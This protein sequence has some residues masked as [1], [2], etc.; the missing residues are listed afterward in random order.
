MKSKSYI[1]IETCKKCLFCG[2]V[3]P[4]LLITKDEEGNVIFCQEYDE[5]CIHCGHCMAVCPTDSISIEGLKYGEQVIP[6]S[7]EDLHSD[8][9][10]SLASKRRA[11]RKYKSKEVEIEKV[12]KIIELIEK[13]PVSFTPNNI[14]IT[15]INGREKLEKLFPKMT[16]FYFDLAH[17][18]NSK[19]VNFFIKQS[20]NSQTYTTLKD[21]IKPLFEY[22]E[23]NFGDEVD[24]IFRGAPTVFIFHANKDAGSHTED[25]L[26]AMTYGVIAAES[27]G[28]GAC[29]VSLIP[30]VLNKSEE[31]K[32]ELKIPKDNEVITSFIA[33]YSKF[34]YKK[35]IVRKMK[36]VTFI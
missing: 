5:L 13:S 34:H 32:K 17:K 29:P 25:G 19:I 14:E 36:N 2:E 9:F 26:I 12:Q 1:N 23:K 31:L 18:L 22:K 28:L 11:I 15:V 30:P 16:K 20:V 3:C 6:I 27:L 7:K 24:A 4:N 10:Q 33:G 8:S 35:T 21:H